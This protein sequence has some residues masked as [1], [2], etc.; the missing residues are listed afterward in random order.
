MEEELGLHALEDWW[1]ESLRD[2]DVEEDTAWPTEGEEEPGQD[3]ELHE[4][5]S[6]DTE[7]EE[8]CALSSEGEEEP[9]L[10]ADSCVSE[11]S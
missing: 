8:E 1:P 3:A 2:S 11:E 6:E 4:L 5:S 7:E 9:S 10:D